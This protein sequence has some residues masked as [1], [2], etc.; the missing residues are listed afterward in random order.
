MTGQQLKEKLKILGIK[1]SDIASNLN[2]TKQTIGEWFEYKTVS[3]DKLEQ[4]CDIYN[5]KINDF[6]IDTKY[7]CKD[8]PAIKTSVERY[9]LE[10]L[11]KYKK[12]Y[13]ELKTKQDIK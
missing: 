4:L 7:D 9:L 13:L 5:L 6:Y 3:T 12:L 1:P 8:T 11:E 10:E 2:K